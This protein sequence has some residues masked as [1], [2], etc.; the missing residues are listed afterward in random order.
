MEKLGLSDTSVDYALTSDETWSEVNIIYNKA[1][2]KIARLVMEKGSY[3]DG[4]GQP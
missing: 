2:L 1:V 4:E 3:G